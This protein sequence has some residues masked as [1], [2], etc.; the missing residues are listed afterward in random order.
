MDIERQANAKINLALDVLSEREDGYHEIDTIMQE[1]DLHD[2]LS[3]EKGRGGFVLTCDHPDL[4]LD[5][6]NLI[7]KAWRALRDRAEEDSVV[8]ELTKRIPIAAGLAGGSTDAAAT[9]LGLNELWSLHLSE[10]ELKDI[11]GELG[12][13]V[14][15]FIKGGTARACGRGE[16]LTPLKNY[17]GKALLLVNNGES[18]SSRYVYQHIKPNGKVRIS[19]L[20]D[21]MSYDSPKAYSLMQNHLE[22]VSFQEVPELAKIKRELEEQGAQ[23]ALMSG[24]GPTMFGIFNDL[25]D[26]QKAA[27]YFVDRYAFVQVARTV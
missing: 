11:A 23:L 15:F 20:I 26:A 5:D 9:L 4:K 19:N 7:Y 16:I 14:P 18:L 13:D 12:S 1:I 3:I 22:S 27:E 25:E 21:L 2:T 8:I 24:S 10:E 17:Y 6:S